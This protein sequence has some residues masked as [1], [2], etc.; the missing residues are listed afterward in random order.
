MIKKLLFIF[1]FSIQIFQKQAF[2]QLNPKDFILV[3]GGTFMMGKVDGDWNEKPAHEV[4][5]NDFYISKYEVTNKEYA[6]FL[7]KYGSD[8]V[9]SGVYKGKKMIFE[10]EKGLYKAGDIWRVHK[11]YEKHP[12]VRV[13]WYGAN[14]YCLEN[15]G[16]LPTEAEWEYAAR[17]GRKN[18]KYK[19]AGSN[20]IETV[21]WYDKNS[22]RQS[23]AVGQKKPNSLGIYDMSGNV[24]EWCSDWYADNYYEFSPKN[25]PQGPASGI[26]HVFRG[27]SWYNTAWDCEV[28]T[29]FNS[30]TW[31][32]Y[33]DI[34]FRMC[35][36]LIET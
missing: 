33:S 17:G 24:W 19:Y 28:D 21:A 1:L 2:A 35:L 27:G 20:D 25:N 13:T 23:R 8:I 3:K 16:R 18:K 29:R 30:N 31:H 12:V 22:N 14:E 36:V 15:G 6:Q 7:N 9:K 34:G 26:Y 5:L 10:Y 32:E 11:G 4:R